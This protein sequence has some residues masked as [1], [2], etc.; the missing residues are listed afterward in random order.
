MVGKLTWFTLW[1]ANGKGLPCSLQT[2]TVYRAVIKLK[3]F[4]APFAN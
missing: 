1:I 4:T 3:L 2:R